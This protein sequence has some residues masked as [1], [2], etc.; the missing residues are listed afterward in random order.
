MVVL[1]KEKENQQNQ[2]NQHLKRRVRD[3]TFFV[4]EF[5]SQ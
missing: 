3:L 1:I 4:Q 2:Q 5:I